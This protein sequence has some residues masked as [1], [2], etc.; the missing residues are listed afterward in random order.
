MRLGGYFWAESREELQP[1]SEKLDCYGLS[2]I[3]TPPGTPD[4]SIDD[5]ERFHEEAARLGIVVGESG[6]W[7]NLMTADADL[8]SRRVAD[9]RKLLTK[10]DAMHCRCVVVLAG[11]RDV[12]DA[13][14]AP[15]P[16]LYTKECRSEFRELVLRILDGLD[17][18]H[19]RFC[20]EPWHNTFFYQPDAIRE[21]IDSV[22]HP[23]F[24]LHLDQMNMIDQVHFYRTTEL[25]NR[26]FDLLSPWVASVHLKDMRCDHSHMFLKWDEVNI[27][28]GVMDYGTYL[29]RLAGLDEDTPCFCEHMEEE[30]DYALNFARLHQLAAREGVSFLRRGAGRQNR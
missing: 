20:V 17:L 4:M 5:C 23:R 28:D 10:A 7:E 2:A 16:Y 6:Y 19:A 14:L 25:I 30:R 13:A 1:L 3:H 11:T 15:H 8:R 12:S 27:G 24:G 18:R 22:A 9:V 21:F 29:R 26:T